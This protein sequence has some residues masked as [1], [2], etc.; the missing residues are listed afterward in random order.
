M[1]IYILQEARLDNVDLHLIRLLARDS[2]TP[3]KNVASTV[4]I[5]PSAAKK[6]I[7]KMISNGAIQRFVVLI[8]PIIFGYERLCVLI[9]RNT[10]KTIK[11]RDLLKKVSLLGN[12][13]AYSEE[14]EGSYIF[15]LYAKDIEQDKIE[16]VTDDMLKPAAVEAVFQLLDHHQP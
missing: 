15:G 14:L 11:E 2:R 5:T 1:L 16:I 4:G 9:V 13:T 6:R 3:Y 8:N 10:D 7:I 12:V